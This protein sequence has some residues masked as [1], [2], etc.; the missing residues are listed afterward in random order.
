MLNLP[1]LIVCSPCH[2]SVLS[3]ACCLDTNSI[4]PPPPPLSSSWS[5]SLLTTKLARASQNSRGESLSKNRK[6]LPSVGTPSTCRTKEE[7]E[8]GHGESRNKGN[9]DEEEDE[10]DEEGKEGEARSASGKRGMTRKHGSEE[11]KRSRKPASIT[12]KSAA[13]R[14]IMQSHQSK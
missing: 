4:C 9:R 11:R 2:Y 3:H 7:K 1:R 5:F 8:Q 14:A 6:A 12:F 13:K 10:E